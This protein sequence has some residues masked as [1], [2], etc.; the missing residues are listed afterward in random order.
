MAS[1]EN[2]SVL[3]E[4]RTSLMEVS[5]EDI[6]EPGAYVEKGSG[7]LFRIPQEGLV[8]G[9]SPLIM[10]ESRGASRLLAVR[11]ARFKLVMR[12]EPGAIEEMYDL[13]AD[14]AEMRPGTE[15]PALGTRKRLLQAAH[16]HMEKTASA[17]DPMM[18]LRARLRDLRCEMFG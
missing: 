18:R 10:K 16:E 17:R 8:R 9:G 2:V 3:P 1:R 11:D 7:D 14:P 6:S 4:N 15:G 13:E 5:W 12:I